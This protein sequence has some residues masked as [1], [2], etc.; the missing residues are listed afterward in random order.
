MNNGQ[1]I[2]EKQNWIKQNLGFVKRGKV[3]N[4]CVLLI[5][6][7]V[8]WISESKY[9]NRVNIFQ[10]DSQTHRNDWKKEKFPESEVKCQGDASGIHVVVDGKA[11]TAFNRCRVQFWLFQR[12]LTGVLWTIY[13]L[14]L[15]DFSSF[16]CRSGAGPQGLRAGRACFGISICPTGESA[17][18]FQSCS[19][20][21]ADQ[22]QY[23]LNLAF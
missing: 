4:G 1:V 5:K 21:H 18:G 19:A 3:D 13:P 6:E 15:F 16:V 22:N 10:N 2:S 23:Q 8:Q 7:K 12:C 14:G 17:T 20:F 11:I 9:F